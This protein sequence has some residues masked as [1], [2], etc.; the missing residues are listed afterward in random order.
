MFADF[1]VNRS[2]ISF[3]FAGEFHDVFGID[4]LR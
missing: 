1:F 2:G 4:D 3:A